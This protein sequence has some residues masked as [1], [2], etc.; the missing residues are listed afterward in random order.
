MVTGIVEERGRL[1]TRDRHRFT[2]T[3]TVVTEDIEVGRSIAVNGCCLT[4]VDYGSGSWS[5]DVVDETLSRTNLSNL[6]PGDEVNLERPVRVGGRL[7]GHIV[8]GHVDGLGEVVASPPELRIRASEALL[9]Y[10]VEK[11]SIAVD[12]CS[13]TVTDVA[14]DIFG[15]SVVPH[16]AAITTLGGRRPGDKV[17]LEVDLVAKYVESLLTRGDP[18]TGA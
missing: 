8:Q 18:R 11:G 17:N 4:V 12:G 10:I 1:S 16:T 13:L 2:F 3:A 7:D 9:P 6:H 15:I 5:A 14:G